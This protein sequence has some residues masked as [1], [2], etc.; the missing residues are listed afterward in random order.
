MNYVHRS[1]VKRPIGIAN[2]KKVEGEG[3]LRVLL[4]A[5]TLVMP[6]ASMAYTKIKYTRFSYE[7]SELHNQTVQQEEL[8]RKL[9]LAR[10]RYQRDEE[11][12]A[13]AERAGL[14]PRKQ[15]HFVPRS[16][17]QEDQRLAKLNI[18]TESATF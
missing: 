6:F 11:V 15:I 7:M 12:R 3:A 18:G 5:F 4:L 1:H 10:S 8:Q 2:R 17:T 16:F 13:F 14:S 9:L